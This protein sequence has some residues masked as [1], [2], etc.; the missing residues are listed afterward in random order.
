[1]FPFFPQLQVAVPVIQRTPLAITNG[2]N[3]GTEFDLAKW[4][5]ESF[6][7]FAAP[8]KRVGNENC[9]SL[10]GFYYEEKIA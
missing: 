7:Q 5:Q 8:K 2:N 6:L 3:N 9:Y 4:I 1:M 10:L